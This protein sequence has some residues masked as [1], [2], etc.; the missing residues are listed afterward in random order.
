EGDISI[1]GFDQDNRHVFLSSRNGGDR[2]KLYRVD[3]ETGEL[4]KPLVSDPEYDVVGRLIHTREG[5]PLFFRYQTD[6]PRTLFFEQ[7]WADR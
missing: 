3:G 2:M 6:K 7:D 4:G 5:K 1:H